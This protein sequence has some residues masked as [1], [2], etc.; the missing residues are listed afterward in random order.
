LDSS[1]SAASQLKTL[2]WLFCNEPIKNKTG[3][4]MKKSLVIFLFVISLTLRSAH[5]QGFMN[6]DFE[7]ARLVPGPNFGAA[8]NL[9][10]GWSA[11][12]YTN[13]LSNIPYNQFSF[14]GLPADVLYGT[15][16]YVVNGN[17]SLLLGDGSISQ[18][19]LVPVG[20]VSLLFDVMMGGS[21]IVSLG[22]QDLSYMAVGSGVNSYGT[23]YTIYAANI[24]ALAGQVEAL[25]FSGGGIL[26]DIQFSTQPVPE[27]SPLCL[28][29][30][31]GVLLFYARKRN[32]KYAKS[33]APD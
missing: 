10:P 32:Q 27:P 22:G 6:L 33:A 28:L 8:T 29:L 1:P 24:S 26:D 2:V 3:G 23:S 14:I 9:L 31:D 30:F 5:G 17:F 16:S 21:P 25:T 19:G 11:F 20:A 13:Q 15:N 7:S 18:T 4:I 12:E